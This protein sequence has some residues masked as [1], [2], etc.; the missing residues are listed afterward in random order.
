[1]YIQLTVLDK[2]EKIKVNFFHY[3]IGTEGREV[4]ATLLPEGPN[5]LEQLMKAFDKCCDPR[6][7][8]A[9]ER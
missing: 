9:I 3:F 6:I 8:G 1:M 2:D 7:N 4:S 5:T